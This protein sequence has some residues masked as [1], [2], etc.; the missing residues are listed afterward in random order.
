MSVSTTAR[1]FFSPSHHLWIRVATTTATTAATTTCST[2]T[3]KTRF[4]LSSK[5]KNNKNEQQWQLNS[6]EPHTLLLDV[7]F[8]LRG[9]E[10]IGDINTITSTKFNNIDVDKKINVGDDIVEIE[11]D[12]HVHSEAD[13]LYHAVWETFTNATIVSSPISGIIRD[14]NVVDRPSIHTVVDE[15]TTLF[16]VEVDNDSYRNL[17]NNFLSEDMY[18]KLIKRLPR[19][20]FHDDRDIS[21]SILH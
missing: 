19:G 1:K 8:T 21:N 4:S 14:I 17:S 9:L 11:W 16:S 5:K 13:E 10:D 20:M 3:T 6:N 18:L 15:D 7:G 12:G 2:A